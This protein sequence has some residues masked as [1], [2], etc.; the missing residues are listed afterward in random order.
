MLRGCG[1]RGGPALAS[2]PFG[3]AAWPLIVCLIG[4]LAIGLYDKHVGF[5][6]E[7]LNVVMGKVKGEGATLTTTLASARSR[8]CCRFFVRRQRG[9][10]RRA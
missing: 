4:G 1:G 7:E 6:P 9:P 5:A 10:L 2:G 8:R 3:F